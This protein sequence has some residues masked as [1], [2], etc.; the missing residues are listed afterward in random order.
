[1]IDQTYDE[2]YEQIRQQKINQAISLTRKSQATD[3]GFY[4]FD[5]CPF[6][7]AGDRHIRRCAAI[8]STTGAFKCF[9]CTPKAISVDAFLHKM[10][11]N[12]SHQ[13]PAT[14]IKPKPA[15]RRG[16]PIWQ[17]DPMKYHSRLTSA[18][19]VVQQWQRYKPITEDMIMRFQLGYGVLPPVRQDKDGTLHYTQ[20]CSHPRL[21][22]ANLENPDRQA[23]AFRGR[24]LDCSCF[25]EKPGDLKWLTI[26]G[27]DA[28]LFNSMAVERSRGAYIIIAEQPIDSI[29]AMQ[30]MPDVLAVAGTAGAGTW[31]PEWSQLI[32]KAE[33]RGVL[34]W[35]DNDL[36]GN[37]NEEAREGLIAARREKMEARGIHVTDSMIQNWRRSAMAPQIVRDLRHLHIPAETFNWP[38]GTQWHMDA[39]QYLI[40]Q[41][42]F[43]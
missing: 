6:C 26:T 22:Y 39:G 23:T 4:Q 35:Y 9:R 2:A 13:I 37:P 1:M 5:H 7:G 11:Q 21:T 33:P 12:P 10:G 24:Q 19:D 16:I 20:K 29:L 30:A 25:K 38:L 32:A 14:I 34:V 36:I 42:A 17:L 27:A 3:K 40:D 18:A 15:Q 41:G 8:G 31:K 28:W 43:A